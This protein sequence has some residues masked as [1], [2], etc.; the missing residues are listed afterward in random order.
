MPLYALPHAPE[1]FKAG[2][3]GAPVT[4][5]TSYDTIYTERYMG[6]PQGNPQGYETSPPPQKAGGGRGGGG[7]GARL[8]LLRHDLHG[9]LHGHAA[10]QPAGLRDELAAQEG[11]RAQGGAA[12]HPR[13]GGRQRAP[14]QHPRLRRRAHQGG[15]A[16]RAARAPAADARLS[17]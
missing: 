12:A 14:P 6:T 16:A 9:A 15:P 2:V 3:A 4:D 17:Q 10:G 7:A 8:D 11:G 13:L 1:V 5:W